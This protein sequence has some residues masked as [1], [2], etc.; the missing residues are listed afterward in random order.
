MFNVVPPH[1]ASACSH[2]LADL[3]RFGVNAEN[4]LAS[5]YG[6]GYRLSD[7]LP[8]LHRQ[9]P[10][11]VVLTTC[12]QIWN[13]IRAFPVQS[14][15]QTVFAVK[16]IRFSCYG[17]CDDFYVGEGGY[18][19]AARSISTLINEISCILLAYLTYFAELCDEVVHGYDDGS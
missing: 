8:E 13:G 6:L 9:F 15:K 5:I 4:I 12:N 10:A 16:A 2:V 7:T 19:P 18:H 3:N 11:L 1:L 14:G 17:Q